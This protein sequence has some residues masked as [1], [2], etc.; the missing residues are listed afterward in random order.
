VLGA[1]ARVPFARE[2]QAL[3]D[4]V[5]LLLRALDTQGVERFDPTRRQQPLAP[6]QSAGIARFRQARPLGMGFLRGLLTPRHLALAGLDAKA[7]WADAEARCGQA[8]AAE[9]IGTHDWALLHFQ[10]G[11]AQGSRATT[12]RSTVQ[13]IGCGA[14]AE[15]R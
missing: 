10:R 1:K 3:H 2:V 15:G 5:E 13:T 7:F 8:R 12:A 6:L 4:R 14:P 9:L 11:G